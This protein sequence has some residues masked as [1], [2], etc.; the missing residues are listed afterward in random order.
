MAAEGDSSQRVE[1]VHIQEPGRDREGLKGSCER[2]EKQVKAETEVEV[3]MEKRAT[4]QAANQA[5]EVK[6]EQ[7]HA[8]GDIETTIEK[9]LHR[10]HEP[11]DERT[12]N[13]GT[14]MSLP[15]PSL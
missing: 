5:A 15:F 12:V 13:L 14:S 7:A 8:Q 2:P 11:P 6:G 4:V 1:R 9:P 10:D 3:E